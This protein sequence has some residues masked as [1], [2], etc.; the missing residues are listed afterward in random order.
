MINEDIIN[1][2]FRRYGYEAESII[3]II[4]DESVI[5]SKNIY[6]E[7]NIKD[8]FNSGKKFVAINLLKN[9]INPNF[10]SKVTHFSLNYINKLKNSIK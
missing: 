1:D 6:K 2:I 10:I 9:N 4:K 3:T 5:D 8:A 7:N